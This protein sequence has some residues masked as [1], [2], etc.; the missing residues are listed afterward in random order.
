MERCWVV[1]VVTMEWCWY[2]DVSGG[3]GTT[4]VVATREFL[5]GKGNLSVGGRRFFDHFNL[6]V[7]KF[8]I[9]AAI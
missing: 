9:A 2:S 1:V 4:M 3:G 5:V 6:V 8:D 7:A